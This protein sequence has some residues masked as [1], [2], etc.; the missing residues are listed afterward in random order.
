MIRKL[1][2]LWNNP[3]VMQ[4]QVKFMIFKGKVGPQLKELIEKK[5]LKSYSKS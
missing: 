4:I 2:R 5:S 1:K 3:R